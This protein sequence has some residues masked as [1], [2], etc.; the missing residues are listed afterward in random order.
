MKRFLFTTFLLVAVVTSFCIGSWNGHRQ[1]AARETPEARNIL[2]YV[3]PMNPAHTSDQP[4]FAPCG[5]KMEPVYADAAET[6]SASG[7]APVSLAPGAVRMSVDKQQLIGVRL[8]TVE[9]KELRHNFRLL[10]RVSVDETRVYSI[11]ATADGWITSTMPSA[12]GDRASTA[13]VTNV[14]APSTVPLTRIRAGGSGAI[15]MSSAMPLAAGDHVQKDEALCAFYSPEFLAPGQALLSALNAADRMHTSGQETEMKRDQMA[16][17]ELNLKQYKDPL[18]ILGMG[19][20][21]IQEMI[22]TRKFIENVNITSPVNGFIIACNVSD[23]QRFKRGTELYRIA[24]FRRV[25]ILADMF[26]RDLAFVQPGTRVRFSVPRQPQIFTATVSQA[27]PQFD[28]NP[29]TGKLRLEA[30]NP[31]FALKPGMFVDIEFPVALPETVVVPADALLDSGLRK[32]VFV[33][34]SRGVFEPRPVEVG[35]RLGDQVQVLKGLMPDERIVVSGTFLLDSESR[36]KLA[37]AGVQRTAATDLV[38]GM[39]VD[40][41]KARATKRTS[42]HAGQTYFFCNLSCKQA[43]EKDPAKYVKEAKLVPHDSVPAA[44]PASVVAESEDAE[45]KDLVCGM[46][47]DRKEAKTA[48]L[49]SEHEGNVYYFCADSCKR[50]FDKEPESFLKAP[51]SAVARELVPPGQPNTTSTSP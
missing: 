12:A 22:R 38:C 21:Q 3:D 36:I 41:E 44:T 15:P 35:Q 4:G 1:S 37:A 39:T 40:E 9:R 32:F 23:G 10:G 6:A 14:V 28:M 47:V 31:G 49:T 27:L 16:Q 13:V 46:M 2:H 17:Y 51:K 8:A 5:M 7:S 30:D 11:N 18:K 50:R 43:F 48:A 45:A 25:W 19:D 29:R 26:E 42:E 24:D 20:R 33:E 34:S